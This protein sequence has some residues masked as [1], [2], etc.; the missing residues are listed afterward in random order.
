MEIQRLSNILLSDLIIKMVAA[1]VILLL[2]LLLGR[3][4]EKLIKKLFKEF[5]V[6]KI[7]K[8]DTGLKFSFENFLG[9]L[10]KWVIYFV[11][12]IMALNQLRITTT[13]LNIF[14]GVFLLVIV[15]ILVLGFKDFIPNI[16]AGISIYRKKYVKVGDD[17]QMEGVKGK[18]VEVNLLD[19]KI[20]TKKDDKIIIP[21]SVLLK[22]VVKNKT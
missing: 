18:V 9:K 20:R 11:A 19:T 6:D 2:G 12:V 4:L 21:N 17:L 8:E 1:I 7:L 15:V 10:V 5:N 14:L 16:I 13:V 3:F 22:R